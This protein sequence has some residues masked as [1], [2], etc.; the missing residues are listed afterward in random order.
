LKFWP[1]PESYSTKPPEKGAPGSF[2]EDREDRHH[3]GVDIYA[4]KGSKVRAVEA[5][6]IIEIGPFT[7]PELIPYW[8]V[9][10][11]ILI[12]I[13]NGWVSKYAELGEVL[14]KAGER[15]RGGQVIGLVGSVL[16]SDKITEGSPPY[17]RRLRENGNQSMLHFEL[18][19]EKPA[20]S[21]NY[22]GGNCFRENKPDGLLDAASYLR[23]SSLEGLMISKTKG[24]MP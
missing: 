21:E 5:G 23:D 15:V 12:Q 3:C 18:Y 8:N 4:P 2:W 19:E 22:L 11:Y 10:H 1:V 14:V 20:S 17:I 24:E 9:T 16:N 7:S 13:Q 6:E